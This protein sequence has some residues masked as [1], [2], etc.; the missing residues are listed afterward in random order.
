MKNHILSWVKAARPPAFVNVGLP[1]WVGQATALKELGVFEWQEFIFSNFLAV[2]IQLYIIFSND[3]ADRRADAAN[4]N[5]TPFSGGS[6]VIIEGK[7][8]A[9]ELRRASVFMLFALI[10][11]NISAA[12]HF[13]RFWILG[14]VCAGIF[15]FRMYSFPPFKLN[16]R[17]GGEYLQV[18]GCGMILPMTGFYLQ[19]NQMT[20]DSV[21][22]FASY[23][24]LQL[25]SAI[26]TGIPDKKADEQIGKST[27]PVAFGE[28]R[29]V[30][31]AICAGSI[32]LLLM[33]IL[34]NDGA[35]FEPLTAFFVPFILL[36]CA[37]TLRTRITESRRHCLIF[38]SFSLGAV[39][40]NG[41]GLSIILF[42]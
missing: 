42:I 27:I 12:V 11:T 22:F 32:A 23:S 29:A 24:L 9:E 33:L 14:F 5:R 35:Y 37:D 18:F 7:I 4:K 16:Y 1:L 28:K 21:M 8:K 2:L 41:I 25:C 30:R 17:G 19:T 6:G 3:F 38:C 10:F 34:H 13:D 40:M 15:I 20:L 31:L 26:T 39:A 36:V